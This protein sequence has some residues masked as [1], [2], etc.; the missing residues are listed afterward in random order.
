MAAAD[1]LLHRLWTKAV[2]APDYDKAE[3]R[4]LE[5]VFE[6]RGSEVAK[7][8]HESGTAKGRA[9]KLASAL[10]L[11]CDA[12]DELDHRGYYQEELADHR[13]LLGER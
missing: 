2:G 3:W 6:L 7:W 10:S 4:E 11:A 1:E 13:R 5:R 9:D 12:I 8:A